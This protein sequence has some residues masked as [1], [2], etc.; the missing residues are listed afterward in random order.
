MIIWIV[1]RVIRSII[2]ILVT[3]WLILEFPQTFDNRYV[4]CKGFFELL[5]LLIIL[6]WFNKIILF[7]LIIINI[8]LLRVIKHYHE[9]LECGR[10]IDLIDSCAWFI[11]EF[12][13]ELDKSNVQYIL[14]NW[15]GHSM[16]SIL[17]FDFANSTVVTI[18]PEGIFKN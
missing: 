10:D 4:W 3:I 9:L 14:K 7:A 1:N 12:I 15:A 11:L 6:K 5:P 18:I 16:E 13:Q 17:N 2:V 8:D